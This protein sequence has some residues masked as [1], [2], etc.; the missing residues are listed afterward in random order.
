MNNVI[1]IASTI[2]IAACT[3]AC[4]QDNEPQFGQ[5]EPDIAPLQQELEAGRSFA[6]EASANAG[7]LVASGIWLDESPTTFAVVIEGGTT[8]V[9]MHDDALSLNALT[10]DIADL[11]HELPGGSHLSD[12]AL[13]LEEPIVLDTRWVDGRVTGSAN[14]VL[15]L[16]WA[17]ATESHTSQLLSQTVESLPVELHIEE[18][19][20]GLAFAA[21]LQQDGLVFEL[22]EL[23]AVERFDAEIAATSVS[24]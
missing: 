14:L 19:D 6:L 9:A 5:H 23:F 20:D 24:P 16:D 12:I 21:Q 18:T 15:R 10:I 11:D 22:P 3:T 1:T 17:I 7:E 4:T 13:V 8:S 2:I